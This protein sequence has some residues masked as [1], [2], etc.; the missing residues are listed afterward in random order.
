MSSW[1]AGWHGLGYNTREE[2]YIQKY[3]QGTAPQGTTNSALLCDDAWH[4]DHG[5]LGHF[6]WSGVTVTAHQQYGFSLAKIHAPIKNEQ[7]NVQ[8]YYGVYAATCAMMCWTG[9]A[10]SCQLQLEQQ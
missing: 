8:E 6:L 7:W 3:E 10:L 1:F 9:T 4:K 5:H 2:V